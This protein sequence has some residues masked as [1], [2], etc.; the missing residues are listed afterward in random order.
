MFPLLK[1]ILALI[2]IVVVTLGESITSTVQKLSSPR[3]AL[4]TGPGSK[5]RGAFAFEYIIVLVIMVAI[6]LAAFRILE[7]MVM[8]KINCMSA[9]VGGIG[10]SVGGASGASANCSNK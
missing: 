4:A 5:R 3:L 10:S 1:R 9:D 8:N 6:I 7:P 2:M